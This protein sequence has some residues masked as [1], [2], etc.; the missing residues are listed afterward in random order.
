MPPV[1]LPSALGRR[2]VKRTS[3][4]TGVVARR[5]AKEKESGG[6]LGA[7]AG[8]AEAGLAD[9]RVGLREEVL[10]LLTRIGDQRIGAGAGVA[11]GPVAV[12]TVHDRREITCPAVQQV[13]CPAPELAS[14][15][16]RE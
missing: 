9:E 8:P 1:A 4:G 7:V 16:R 15:V 11:G 10:G 3:A 6:G 13:G 14:F 12:E 5:R 2:I